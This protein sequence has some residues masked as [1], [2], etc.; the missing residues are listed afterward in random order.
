MKK[1]KLPI[2]QFN[3]RKINET[4]VDKEIHIYNMCIKYGIPYGRFSN[5][6][7]NEVYREDFEEKA[8]WML[9]TDGKLTPELEKKLI[10]TLPERLER[11]KKRD[12]KVKESQNDKLNK[13]G[14][15]YEGIKELLDIDLENQ[16][17]HGIKFKDIIKLHEKAQKKKKRK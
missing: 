2:D 16:T 9:L 11:N 4:A 6:E 7:E 5:S 13:A 1:N 14:A 8:Y 15:S 17:M 10:D 3:T 12:E